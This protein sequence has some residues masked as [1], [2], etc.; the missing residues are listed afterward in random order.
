MQGMPDGHI[1]AKSVDRFAGKRG[2]CFSLARKP[3][4]C[5]KRTAPLWCA[6]FNA[7]I[8]EVSGKYLKTK[9]RRFVDLTDDKDYSVS[10]T[11]EKRKFDRFPIDFM[12]AVSGE[13]REGKK[14]ED[15][16]DLN[17]VSGEGAKFFT[18]KY[19]RYFLGQAL[20]IKIVLPGTDDGNRIVQTVR[21]HLEDLSFRGQP[22]NLSEVREKGN[23]GQGQGES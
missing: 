1:R 20:E 17:D 23:G 14:F 7:D 15:K 5:F 18:D 16:T 3:D 6:H 22:I 10:K 19:D 8:A 13:D 2:H 11:S 21:Q 9:T 4:S 12:L